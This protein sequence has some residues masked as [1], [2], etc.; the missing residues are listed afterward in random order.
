MGDGLRHFDRRKSGGVALGGDVVDR[1][2]RVL[3][4]SYVRFEVSMKDRAIDFT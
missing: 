4:L 2:D 1:L 3:V